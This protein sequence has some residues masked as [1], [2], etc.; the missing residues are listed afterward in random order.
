MRYEIWQND[1]SSTLFQENHPQ[2]NLL[3]EPGAQC[4]GTVEADSWDEAMTKYHQF[5]EWEPY[6][7]MD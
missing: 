3:I 1:T 5:M 6:V 4:V 7:P 2:R